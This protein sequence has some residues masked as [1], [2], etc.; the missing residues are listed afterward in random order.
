M[1]QDP[2]PQDCTLDGVVEDSRGVSS[3]TYVLVPREASSTWH[4]R[5]LAQQLWANDHQVVAVDLSG[6]P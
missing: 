2:T 1:S 6:G 3:F 4:W 5:L